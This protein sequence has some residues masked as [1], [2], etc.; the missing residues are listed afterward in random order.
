MKNVSVQ[1]YVQ[2][3]S[4]FFFFLGGG[5]CFVLYF[6]FLPFG[7]TEPLIN[8]ALGPEAL[9][10]SCSAAVETAIL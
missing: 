8:G 7:G 10:S 4:I 9:K 5:A 1:L 2:I 3:F 6:S